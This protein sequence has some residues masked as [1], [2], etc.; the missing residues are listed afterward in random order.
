MNSG[1]PV[2]WTCPRVG[3]SRFKSSAIVPPIYLGMMTQTPAANNQRKSTRR[4]M[5]QRVDVPDRRAEGRAKLLL[6]AGFREPYTTR[7]SAGASPSQFSDPPNSP[8][9][10]DVAQRHCPD[11]RKR[12]AIARQAGILENES[13]F[14]KR[15]ILDFGF[16][17]GGEGEA[18]TKCGC[19]GA[20]LFDCRL[21]AVSIL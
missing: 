4:P 19:P 11:H 7:G 18:V 1:P 16:W 2:P 12:S 9:P 6:S 20:S 15:A 5:N 13:A 10:G 14:W 21:A 8:T 17:I 3:G